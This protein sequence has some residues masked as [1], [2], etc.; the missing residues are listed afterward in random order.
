MDNPW[1]AILRRVEGNHVARTIDEASLYTNPT[2]FHV[3][4]ARESAAYGSADFPSLDGLPDSDIVAHWFDAHHVR[5]AE[6]L[7]QRFA[8][9]EAMAV[10]LN[11]WEATR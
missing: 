11:E 5:S 7:R 8:Q 10:G 1:V 3:V 2:A 6:D 9:A 4:I